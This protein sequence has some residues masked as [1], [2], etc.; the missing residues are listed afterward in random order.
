MMAIIGRHFKGNASHVLHACCLVWVTLVLKIV[1]FDLL[2]LIKMFSYLKSCCEFR[3]WSCSFTV[4][5]PQV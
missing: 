2:K 4:G 1:K 3:R 5:R